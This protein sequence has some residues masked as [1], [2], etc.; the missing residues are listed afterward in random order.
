MDV[1]HN[2]TIGSSFHMDQLT[3]SLGTV[4]VGT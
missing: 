4:T 1:S 2:D 3:A